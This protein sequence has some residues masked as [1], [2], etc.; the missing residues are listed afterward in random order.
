MVRFLGVAAVFVC[1]P[2]FVF[3]L[4]G[5]LLFLGG[6]LR[7]WSVG[8]DVVAGQSLVIVGGVVGVVVVGDKRK[9]C[10]MVFGW[11]FVW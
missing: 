6:R 9:P 4:G 1:W 11:W 10:H 8:I 2:S 7:W 3:I 5:L